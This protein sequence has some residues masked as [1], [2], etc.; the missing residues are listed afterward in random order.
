MQSEG[1]EPQAQGGHTF[2]PGCGAL[3]PQRGACPRC[4][5]W[6][7]S[8]AVVTRFHHQRAQEDCQGL[9]GAPNCRMA[10]IR[11]QVRA[12]QAT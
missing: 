10:Q 5:C 8:T 11:K 2:P 1:S 3:L 4:H 6:G 9:A 7:H 12:I